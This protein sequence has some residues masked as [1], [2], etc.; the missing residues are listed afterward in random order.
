MPLCAG[1]RQGSDIVRATPRNASA[2]PPALPRARLGL[3][4]DAPGASQALGGKGHLS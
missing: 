1:G 3:E 4:N 2:S